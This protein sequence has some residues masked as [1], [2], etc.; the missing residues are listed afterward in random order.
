MT[1]VKRFLLFT[2]CL[3]MV[4][5]QGQQTFENFYSG[6]SGKF[7]LI[8]LASGNLVTSMVGG[9]PMPIIVSGTSIIAPDGSVIHSHA[10]F[11]DTLLVLQAIQR[12]NDNEFYFVTGYYKDSCSAIGS[13]TL[14]N[15][16][17]LIGKMDSLGNMWDLRHY[18]LDGGGC[19]T[20]ITN[21][22][23]KLAG[24]LEVCSNGSVITWGRDDRFF[25]LRADPTGE[26]EWAKCFPNHGGFQFIKEL[27]G[28]DLLAGINMDSAGAVVARMDAMGN[29]LWI[30]SYV[31]PS[32]MVHDAVIESDSSF[33][34]IG[35]TDSL[36]STNPF[37]PNPPG[38][39]PLLFMLKLDGSGDVHWCKGYDSAPNLWYARQGF[40]IERLA[41]D[42][43]VLWAT[44]GYPQNNL[45]HRPLLMKT[46]LNGDTLWTRSSGAAG[47]DYLT[48]D[49]LPYSDGGFMMSGY[50]LGSLPGGNTG[51][52]SIYKVDSLGHF[53][54][55]E[56]H[57]PIEVMDLFPVDSSFT[58][59]STD[60]ATMLPAYV[61][62]TVHDPVPV[63]DACPPTVVPNLYNQGRI[64]PRVRPNPN[65]GQFTV[66]FTDPLQRDSYYSV[67]D[68]T[69][70][71]L[72]QRP[73]ARGATQQDIDLSR[74]GRGTY[75]LHFTTPEGVSQERV[76]VE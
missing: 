13:M 19:G 17:P 40:R 48:I 14:P 64:K 44:L 35:V 41:D 2:A 70:R 21:G 28:G 53:A 31:R 75:I 10:Y 32:G 36:A 50:A 52:T 1:R 74:F 60:G 38:F 55:N 30:K 22:C 71:L 25:A 58:L 42:H 5:A 15:T 67:F 6:A 8:E 59:S 29:F 24:D 47:R 73:L 33:V 61:T 72:F 56:L 4:A 26:V 11:R 23:S 43:Y 18:V 3:C 45:H 57:Y 39:H 63:Y 66:D 68:A 37:V 27:P 12:V 49:L 34:I 16:H 46:D 69:G 76:V 9:S 20:S 62:D 65:T 7:R 51:L 54:C